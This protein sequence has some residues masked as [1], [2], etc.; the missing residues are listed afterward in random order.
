MDINTKDL[1][2]Q[3]YGYFSGIKTI[4]DLLQN[5]G[6]RHFFFGLISGVWIGFSYSVALVASSTIENPSL[7]SLVLGMIFPT[8]IWLIFFI[9]GQ[10]FTA[11]TAI[12]PYLY[13]GILNKRE[14]LVGLMCV[15][16]GNVLGSIIFSFIFALAACL[17]NITGDGLGLNATGQFIYNTGVK[18][19]YYIG[20][21]NENLKGVG[22]WNGLTSS[23]ILKT[24]AICF[25][26]GIL[27]NSLVSLTI[28]GG[29]STKGSVW[30]MMMMWFI[31]IFTFVTVGYQHSV[32]NWA[33]I[34][35][36]MMMWLFHFH[37]TAGVDVSL[38]LSM[39][40]IVFNIIPCFLGNLVGASLMGE[41][42]ISIN[43]EKWKEFIV[44]LKNAKE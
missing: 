31:L 2:Y 11:Y 7:Q 23:S 36:I 5:K 34:G 33:I 41:M 9:G 38:S 16:V 19:I 30:P 12:L 32:A 24:I 26:S 42:L 18:K 27:C 17:T 10:F 43:R 21:I 3:E 29:K 25:F 35:Y 15:Y 22:V 14:A 39:L 4:A 44:T 6:T 8:V 28:I 1:S 40:M 37:T 20:I 13:R